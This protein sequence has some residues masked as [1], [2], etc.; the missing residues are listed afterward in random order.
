MRPK[1]LEYDDSYINKVRTTDHTGQN[2]VKVIYDNYE[3]WGTRERKYDELM[4][5]IRNT[6][7]GPALEAILRTV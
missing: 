4:D 6:F 3:E 1:Y 7:F 2:K 5:C